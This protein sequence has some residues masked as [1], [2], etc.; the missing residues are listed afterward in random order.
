MKLEM[1]YMGG[2][3]LQS[4]LRRNIQPML[5]R[6]CL[7]GSGRGESAHVRLCCLHVELMSKLNRSYVPQLVS[8]HLRDWSQSTAPDEPRYSVAEQLYME[9]PG[10][11]RRRTRGPTSVARY[12]RVEEGEGQ[13]Q[14]PPRTRVT[15]TFFTKQAQ[16]E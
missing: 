4:G 6:G 11:I 10:L 7:P 1:H 12:S 2:V 9:A 5:Q 8:A 14:L 13:S 16:S 3:M 15:E